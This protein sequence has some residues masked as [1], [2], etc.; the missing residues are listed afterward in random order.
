MPWLP[1]DEL[2]NLL[3]QLDLLNTA[4]SCPDCGTEPGHPHEEGCDIER[5]S[6]CGRQRLS[7]GCVG[8]H[9][10]FFAR[11]TGFW[12]GHLEC[13]VL[14]L[15]CR[16]EPDAANLVP[17]DSLCRLPGVDLNR[18]IAEGWPSI[19]WIKPGSQGTQHDTSIH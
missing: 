4:Q 16:W 15:V 1:V 6:A 10:K 18:F 9:D 14:G 7:C 5:C 19:F 8:G 11:W 13:L 17:V 12:P 3:T 2:R